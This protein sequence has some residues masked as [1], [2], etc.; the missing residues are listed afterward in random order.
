M[1]QI[2]KLSNFGSQLGV[3]DLVGGHSEFWGLPWESGVAGGMSF[4][5]ELFDLALSEGPDMMLDQFIDLLGS[6]G[7][8]MS[9]SKR[10]VNTQRG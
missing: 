6:F 5:E 2:S 7:S 3:L 1:A 9:Y 8:R 4:E 10:I